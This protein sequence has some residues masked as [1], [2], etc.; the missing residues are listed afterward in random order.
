LSI[1]KPVILGVKPIGTGV[2]DFYGIREDDLLRR[3]KRTEKQRRLAVYLYKVFS[4]RKN[5]EIGMVFGISIQ[6]DTNAVRRV[7]AIREENEQLSR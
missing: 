2:T 6:G 3:N 1:K 5:T 4:E 7:E